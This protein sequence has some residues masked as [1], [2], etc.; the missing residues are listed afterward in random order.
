MAALCEANFLRLQRVLKVAFPASEDGD[1]QAQ[2]MAGDA[3][4]VEMPEYGAALFLE[5][6][7][8]AIARHNENLRQG[9]GHALAQLV[10]GLDNMVPILRT[11]AVIGI[12]ARIWPQAQEA[13]RRQTRWFGEFSLDPLCSPSSGHRRNIRLSRAK[14]GA[15]QKSNNIFA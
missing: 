5:F 13:G 12:D 1:Q 10:V 4:N 7:D 9:K 6:C 11:D 14:A 2:R 15:R 3:A 8:I